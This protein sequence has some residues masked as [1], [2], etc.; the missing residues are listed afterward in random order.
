MKTF[1]E[2]CAETGFSKNNILSRRRNREL[3]DARQLIAA[4]LHGYGLSFGAIGRVMNRDHTSIMH[5][6]KK[7]KLNPLHNDSDGIHS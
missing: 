5:L 1:E 3:V 6:C 2:L 4:K 7:R